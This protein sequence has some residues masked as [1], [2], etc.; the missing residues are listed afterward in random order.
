MHFP[1]WNSSSS[2]KKQMFERTSRRAF[3]SS[4]PIFL[5]HIVLFCRY[6]FFFQL[7]WH[8]IKTATHSK[9]TPK[10]SFSSIDHKKGRNKAREKKK[11]NKENTGF[12]RLSISFLGCKIVTEIKDKKKRSLPPLNVTK[13][14]LQITDVCVHVYVIYICK[15]GSGGKYYLS[16]S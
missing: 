7:F 10:A 13:D 8:L 11:R 16:M 9:C 15:S 5:S 14:K 4:L 2:Q 1:L 3:S 6:T 12:V